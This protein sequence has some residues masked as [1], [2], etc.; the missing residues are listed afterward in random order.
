MRKLE[1]YWD[2][3]SPY[4]HLAVTQLDG[5]AQ[6]TGAEVELIPFLLGGVFKATENTMP[7]RVPKKAAY[8]IEDLRR[9]RDR[10]GIAMKMPVV[11]VTFPLNTLLPMRV[12]VAA[13]RA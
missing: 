4:T 13:K 5:L 7:A 1:V 3:G 12:A 6:R 9:W 2:V 11:E 8:L 10:Y